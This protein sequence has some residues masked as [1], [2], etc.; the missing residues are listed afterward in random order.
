MFVWCVQ[1]RWK[2][3][4]IRSCDVRLTRRC[5]F[6][7]WNSWTLFLR[8]RQ[9][10]FILTLKE[11]ISPLPLDHPSSLLFVQ[12]CPW[13]NYIE[14]IPNNSTSTLAEPPWFDEPIEDPWAWWSPFFRE[15]HINLH[16]RRVL[17]SVPRQLLEWQ[18]WLSLAIEMPRD[19][20]TFGFLL[21]DGQKEAFLWGDRLTLGTVEFL[22]ALV[23]LFSKAKTK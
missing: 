15:E 4:S 17:P 21:Q 5:R 8:H 18:E 12:Y 22:S 11:E 13:T 1:R 19:S 23:R 16:P 3:I 20:L 14:M 10:Y 9:N 6:R 2:S 7:L